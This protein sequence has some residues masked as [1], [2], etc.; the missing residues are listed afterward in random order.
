MAGLLIDSECNEAEYEK[1][2]GEHEESNMQDTK[3]ELEYVHAAE[4]LVWLCVTEDGGHT[5]PC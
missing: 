1:M 5:H 3:C 4:R 2:V